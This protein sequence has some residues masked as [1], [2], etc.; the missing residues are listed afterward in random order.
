MLH[1]NSSVP[2]RN[3]VKMRCMI[4]GKTASRSKSRNNPDGVARAA[5]HTRRRL[6]SPC[7]GTP[8]TRATSCSHD[9]THYAVET[10]LGFGRG[11]F[12]FSMKAGKSRTPPV[13]AYA[14][15]FP[16]R[17]ARSSACRPLRYRAHVGHALDSSRSR[18]LAPRALTQEQLLEILGLRAGCSGNG[19]RWNLAERSNCDLCDSKKRTHFSIKINGLCDVF[20]GLTHWGFHLVLSTEAH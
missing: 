9:L 15:R 8:S 17:P 5:L 10:A 20:G 11:F 14:D 7:R 2:A 19:P 1:F 13:K 4:S 16:E 18:T 6:R 12:G 3:R